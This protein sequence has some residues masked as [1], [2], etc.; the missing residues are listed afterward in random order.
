MTPIK[1]PESNVVF[2][3]HQP[4]YQFLPCLR[5]PNGELI[6]CWGLT[7][8]ERLQVLLTGKLWHTIATFNQPLQ[9]QMIEVEKPDFAIK[10]ESLEDRQL[11]LDLWADTKRAA[12]QE[13]EENIRERESRYTIPIQNMDRAEVLAT[14]F[15]AA[16]IDDTTQPFAELDR[17]T[18]T[19]EEAR[20]ILI[21][22]AETPGRN[23][24][25]GAIRGRVI[26]CHLGK[27]YI[28]PH[29]YDEA[30]GTDAALTALLPL[31]RGIN[32]LN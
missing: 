31:A 14:L 27:D 29:R 13:H 15:N 9:P 26:S 20:A 18:M 16:K 30:N 6:V 17:E 24:Y 4:E 23:Q 1:F 22:M 10:P 5:K 25:V 3:E 19:V 11:A 8:K 28:R 21:D 2:A 32:Q 7:I 12:I